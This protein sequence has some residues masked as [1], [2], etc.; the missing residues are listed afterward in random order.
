MDVNFSPQSQKDLDEIHDY[1]A[2]DSPERALSWIRQIETACT[3][4]SEAPLL[5][6][7]LAIGLRHVRATTYGNYVIYYRVRDDQVDI[8][9]VVHGARRPLGSL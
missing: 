3:S 5:G 9:R 6:T 2:A 1:I 8:L 7:P 4:L